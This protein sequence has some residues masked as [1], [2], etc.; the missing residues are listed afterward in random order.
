MRLSELPAARARYEEAL[1]LYRA[2]GDK[3]GEANCI[4]SLGDVASKEKNFDTAF[5]LYEEAVAICHTI[6]PAD[7]AS[8][9]NNIAN[10]YD[11]QKEYAKA[12]EAY[13]R[14]LALFPEHA[15]IWRN[16][17]NQY[18]KLKDLV[19]AARDIEAAAELQPDNAYLFLRRGELANLLGKYDEA[20]SHFNAALERYLRMNV[21]WF[22]MGIAH[23][24]AGRP[25]EAIAAYQ[26]GLS[27]TDAR[28]ELDEAL[29][30]LEKLKA[31]QSGLAGVDDVRKMMREWRAV[32][33]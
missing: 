31:E 22:G 3:L 17:A 24:R 2:I 26:R 23:L 30:E 1:P 25:A 16:R 19:N 12:V 10:A 20:I 21:A 14:A 7:E 18:L 27:V 33:G 5:K 6:S 15:Y 9:L 29:D 8:A 13:T 4:R 11:E 28:S 32:S